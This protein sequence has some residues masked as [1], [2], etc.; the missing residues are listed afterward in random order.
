MAPAGTRQFFGTDGI[1]GAVGGQL[2]NGRFFARLAVALRRLLRDRCPAER[3]LRILVGHDPRHSAHH[4]KA[5][6]LRGLGNTVEVLDG[7][8]L[9]TPVLA[10]GVRLLVCDGCAVLT[11]SHNGAGDNGLKLLG[12]DGNKWSVA[13]ELRLESLLTDR[14]REGELVA[15]DLAGRDC[16]GEIFSHYQRRWK[17]FFSAGALSGLRVVLDCANGA[18]SPHGAEFLQN[19]GARVVAIA[20]APN[21]YNIND[22]CGSEHPQELI[23][24]V[25]SGR[26]NW[27][28]ALDGDGDRALL[29]DGEGNVIPGEQLLALLALAGKAMDLRESAAIVTTELANG[30]LDSFRRARGGD[31]RPT[32]GGARAVAEAMGRWGCFLGGE[33]SGHVLVPDFGPL[34]DGLITGALF[35]SCVRRL[36]EEDWRFPLLPTAKKNL[37]V[38][39]KIPLEQLPR[40]C[41]KMAEMG[42]ELAGVGRVLVR[43][44]GTESLLRLQVESEDAARARACVERL[45]VAYRDEVEHGRRNGQPDAGPGSDAH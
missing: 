23:R 32:Q 41:Q 37:P 44:S 13:D 3:R 8:M 30:A 25:R 21:G 27:G 6:L 28:L 4:L 1:R 11:A 24:R 7:G 38:T 35:L 39:A 31:A 33:P 43:Y 45:E 15:G 18:V 5:A 14:D 29:C 10:H 20:A 34:A 36:R 26:A 2:T 19:L 40:F 17:E 16:R 12:P 22:R 9:P 42:R